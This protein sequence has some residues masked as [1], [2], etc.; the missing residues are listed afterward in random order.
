MTEKIKVLH[1]ET[2]WTCGD[3]CCDHYLVVSSF[4]YKDRIYQYESESIDD[5]HS[6]FLKE[7][8]DIEFEDEYKYNES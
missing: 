1:D 5:N 6:R 8:F 7:V 2:S 4:M 3:G